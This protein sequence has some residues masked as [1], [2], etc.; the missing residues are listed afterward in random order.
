M[1]KN[2]LCFKKINA[3]SNISQIKEDDKITVA[4]VETGADEAQPKQIA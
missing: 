2:E 4:N 1:I 3:T